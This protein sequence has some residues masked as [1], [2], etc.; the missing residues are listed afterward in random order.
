MKL[1]I[2]VLIIFFPTIASYNIEDIDDDGGPLFLLFRHV[3]FLIIAFFEGYVI[4]EFN[5]QRFPN[6]HFNEFI[7]WSSMCQVDEYDESGKNC[8][9]LFSSLT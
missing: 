1:D 7:K 5:A 3:L 2:Q 4:C 9:G 8:F 6:S